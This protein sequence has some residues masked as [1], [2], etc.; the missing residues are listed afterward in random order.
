MITINNW[1]ICALIAMTSFASM[2]L[3]I[4]HLTYEVSAPVILF[5]L[6]VFTLLF[7]TIY[8]IASGTKPII[9]NS[10]LLFIIAAAFFAFLGNYFD[11]EAL[12]QAPNTGYASAVKSGQIVIITL[13]AYYIFKDQVLNLTGIIGVLLIVSGVVLL[14]LQ[15]TL[16]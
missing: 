15:K 2:T 8:L 12:R 13:A 3:L 16:A 10:N 9:S 5:F 6:F 14:S 4:K 11:V 1:F 7:F